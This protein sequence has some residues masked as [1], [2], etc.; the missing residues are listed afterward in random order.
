MK[1]KHEQRGKGKEK[2]KKTKRLSHTN[3]KW[4]RAATTTTLATR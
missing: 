4:D 1:R 2:G 3:P